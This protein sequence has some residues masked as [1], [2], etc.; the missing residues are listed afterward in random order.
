MAV[1][2]QRVATAPATSVMG[3]TA[4]R[5]STSQRDTG[6]RGRP[7]GGLVVRSTS[8]QAENRPWTGR[9]PGVDPDPSTGRVTASVDDEEDA[10]DCG[11]VERTAAE[12]V[13]S[14]GWGST[15]LTWA[16]VPTGVARRE[17]RGASPPT[18]PTR[19]RP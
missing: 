8:T 19:A 15:S 16:M 2:G 3:R 5:V 11:G 6:S 7:V 4:A 14:V 10:G 12:P 13:A 17:V 1:D 18:S 9:D